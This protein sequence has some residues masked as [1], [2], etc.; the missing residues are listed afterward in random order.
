MSERDVL[1]SSDASFVLFYSG[2]WP[3]YLTALLSLRLVGAR[4]N[5]H[6][7]NVIR[8]RTQVLTIMR[9]VLHH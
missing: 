3:S 5:V 8:I 9:P 1:A 2:T 6:A 7:H 4:T